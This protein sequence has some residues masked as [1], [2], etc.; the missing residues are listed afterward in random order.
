MTSI[1]N[2]NHCTRLHVNDAF[3]PTLTSDAPQTHYSRDVATGVL[4]FGQLKLLCSEIQFLIAVGDRK[5]CTLIYA[6]ASPGH[7]IPYLMRLF[8]RLGF[9]LVDPKHSVV[10][11]GKRVRII[12]GYMT[13]QLASELARKYGERVLFVSDVRTEGGKHETDDAHQAR[14]ERDMRAQMEWHRI[15]NPR[16]SLLKFR[17]PWNRG[18][19][20][21]YLD[22]AICLPIFGKR[23]T[24]ESRLFVLRG[25]KV[26]EYDNHKYERQMAYFNQITRHSM[27][28][29]GMCFDCFSMCMLLGETAP[30]MMA[31]LR[32]FIDEENALRQ[33]PRPTRP[34]AGPA[35]RRSGPDRPLCTR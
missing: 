7:H 6:G 34:S 33:K 19:S 12:Q 4:H 29:G 24:H 32:R 1:M 17:L 16:A 30:W 15:L 23:F 22:G 3:S 20:S 26:V 5:G 8:P 18:R 31:E 9:V 35:P 2:C 21:S 13:D 14:I 25:A 10:R 27:H 28:P 11:P